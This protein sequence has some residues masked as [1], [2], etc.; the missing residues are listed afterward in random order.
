ML[1]T[2][3]SGPIICPIEEN[4]FLKFSSSESLSM[5]LQY[6]L[7]SRTMI[8]TSYLDRVPGFCGALISTG[9]HIAE[10]YRG[11]GYYKYTAAIRTFIADSL[12]YS[13]IWATIRDD[14]LAEKHC[15]TKYG[16]I[17]KHTILNKRTE[18]LCHFVVLPV[19]NPSLLLVGVETK[20]I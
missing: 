19:P 12:G 2:Y 15:I 4:S 3:S 9:L 8:G 14:N 16:G 6:R 5:G 20:N 18:N 7:A 1:I 13:E 10:P 17:I 11:S